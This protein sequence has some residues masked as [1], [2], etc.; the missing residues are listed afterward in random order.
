MTVVDNGTDLTTL[1]TQ[2]ERA[3]QDLELRHLD[4][5]LATAIGVGFG[6]ALVFVAGRQLRPY[7]EAVPTELILAVALVL[8][9]V[10]GA[11]VAWAWLAG[12][13]ERARYADNKIVA[14]YDSVEQALAAPVVLEQVSD[15]Q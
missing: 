2:D 7:S 10:A 5:R 13:I 1:T 9:L 12:R 3:A 14:V 15:D 8:V 6:G 11:I 4:R